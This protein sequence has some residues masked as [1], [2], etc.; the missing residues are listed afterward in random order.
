MIEI[1]N[2]KEF[3]KNTLQGFFTADLPNADL[4][5]RDCTLHQKGNEQWVGLPTKPYE[6]NQGNTKYSYIIKFKSKER[7]QRFQAECLKALEAKTN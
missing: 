4:E 3:K 6:D 1:I 5:I 2:F 7:W